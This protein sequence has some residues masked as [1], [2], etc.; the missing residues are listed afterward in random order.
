MSPSGNNPERYDVLVVG[1]GPAGC[2][3][4]VAAAILGA[5]T[6]CL[7]I[8]LDSVA[9]HPAGPVLAEGK[10]DPRSALLHELRE[11]GGILPEIL[12]HEGTTT[13]VPEK[14]RVLIDRRRLSLAYKSRLE[15][16]EGVELR[17]GLVVSLEPHDGY[18]LAG[19]KLG[20]TFSANFV[21]VAVGTYLKG[22]VTEAGISVPGGRHGEIPSN[23]LAACLA[24][25]GI[26]LEPA[27]ATCFA[28]VAAG[29]AG[30]AG[31][32]P[33]GE[34][35]R[36]LY[37]LGIDLKGSRAHA[38]EVIRGSAGYN[39]PPAAI[40]APGSL[41]HAWI[42]RSQFTVRHLIL[43]AAQV[44]RDLQSRSL[45]G[46]FF[47]G[48]AAGSCNYSEAAALG[49]L[50]GDSAAVRAKNLAGGRLIK[51][52]KFVNKLVAAVAEQQVRP[53]TIRKP[54]PGC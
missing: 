49:L 33:D 45:P 34:A 9:L 31:L 46:L 43:S 22:T 18:W 54:P 42:T 27:N 4:A 10:D 24:A 36:E 53:V 51:D 52:Y 40:A 39:K 1:G 7:T 3:A 50:A 41:K 13:G 35:L 5:R 28:R 32:P 8:N 20:E 29:S 25:L 17:Q 48:R 19:T 30:G 2:E 44:D 11:I 6:L 21:I 16:T 12:M 47:A 38:L 15:H 26:D 14:G 23:G 37:A